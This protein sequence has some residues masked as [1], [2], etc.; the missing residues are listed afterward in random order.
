MR[1]VGP[2]V[3]TNMVPTFTAAGLAVGIAGPIGAVLCTFYIL[4]RG[5]ERNVRNS[6]AT[7]GAVRRAQPA[8]KS[9]TTVN[10]IP[11]EENWIL[12]LNGNGERPFLY[13]ADGSGKRIYAPEGNR[14]DIE[15]LSRLQGQLCGSNTVSKEDNPA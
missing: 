13:L 2:G 4:A 10:L 1:Q 8:S 9:G 6:R 15:I 11:N 7:T 5:Y 3:R 14:N 12:V